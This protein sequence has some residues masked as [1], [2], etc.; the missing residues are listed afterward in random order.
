MLSL[1]HNV[2]QITAEW[3]TAALSER[4]PGT[5]VASLDI[6]SVIWGTATKVFVEVGYASKPSGGPPAHLCVKGGFDPDMRQ[7]AGVGYQVEARFYSDV[8]P[9]LKGAVPDVWYAGCEAAINQ[10]I[11]ISDDLRVSG[12][13]FGTPYTEPTVD[14]VAAT[15]EL[16]A[17]WH[18]LTWNRRGTADIDWLTVGSQLFRPVAL[19]FLSPEHWAEYMTKPQ[20][21]SFDETLRDRERIQNSITALWRHDDRGVLSISHGDPHIGN[22]YTLGDGVLR[23]LDWQTTNLAPWSDDV[24]YFLTGVLSTEERRKHERE[25]LHHYLEAL[26]ATGA[27]APTFDEAWLS[28]RQH[29]LHGLMFALCPPEMQPADVCTLMGDR[30]AQAAIDLE[31][32]ESI[33]T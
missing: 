28:Y 32:L 17:G 19:S 8:A 15:L 22:T 12:A 20:T 14:D 25:L 31:T 11:V 33:Q 5:R 9:A 23:F 3:L 1:P 24:A 18:G 13:Q 27:S 2:D 16:M 26:S 4:H 21:S 6:E 30:Y 7:I 10:G 29:Q